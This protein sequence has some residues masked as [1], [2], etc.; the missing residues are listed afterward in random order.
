MTKWELMTTPVSIVTPGLPA[1]G[2]PYRVWSHK[3]KD[4][5]TAWDSLVSL[6][7]KGW[8]LVSVT[9]IIGGAQLGITSYLLYTFK[10]PK[11]E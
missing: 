9:P 8:E 6:A 10:R 5:K 2:D 11:P 3:D 1:R 7:D 4:G